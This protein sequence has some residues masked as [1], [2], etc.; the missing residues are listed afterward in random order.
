MVSLG[1]NNIFSQQLNKAIGSWTQRGS[2]LP[3]IP[4]PERPTL[5]PNQFILKVKPLADGS[6]TKFN[7]RHGEFQHI[8][9]RLSESPQK[10]FEQII[11]RFNEC[12]TG[13][14]KEGLFSEVLSF[15]N[16]IYQE[17]STSSIAF[18]PHRLAPFIVGVNQLFPDK[19][20][21]SPARFEMVTQFTDIFYK[22]LSNHAYIAQFGIPECAGIL[23]FCNSARLIVSEYIQQTSLDPSFNRDINPFD[24]GA[25]IETSMLK[26]EEIYGFMCHKVLDLTK[27]SLQS[28]A[29]LTA[30]D[31]LDLAKTIFPN[32]LLN[33]SS[34]FFIEKAHALSRDDAELFRSQIINIPMAFMMIF[35]T[36]ISP[37]SDAHGQIR[38]EA[39]EMLT[40]FQNFRPSLIENSEKDV[41][42]AWLLAYISR[43]EYLYKKL[44]AEGKKNNIDMLIEEYKTLFSVS[45]S[46]GF[47]SSVISRNISLA[48][49]LFEFERAKLSFMNSSDEIRPDSPSSIA[50]C[51]NIVLF[52]QAVTE[53][54]NC[55][56]VIAKIVK[57]ASQMKLLDENEINM[58]K[59]HLE[60]VNT[61][62]NKAK[63]WMSKIKEFPIDSS[64]QL[65]FGLAQTGWNTTKRIIRFEDL[66]KDPKVGT[67]ADD[68][69]YAKLGPLPSLPEQVGTEF[70]LK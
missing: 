11:E 18:E 64:I 32:W 48:K 23:A 41:Q 9:A 35:N 14:E 61:L 39:E 27:S 54:V 46:P 49:E 30:V 53:N 55:A 22:E 3:P 58:I 5:T 43:V 47:R 26:I 63:Q 25:L 4:I 65:S 19:I 67:Q 40:S 42:A 68:I 10:A 36:D 59:K 6:E 60:N 21:K 13:A 16:F 20:F 28:N 50:L 33:P 17:Q 44:N 34:T 24:L 56:S 45:L 62:F 70:E 29:V 1:L 8:S 38:R 2:I 52:I 15:L 31:I 7:I 37:F 69:D 51:D 12:K 66:G 57:E